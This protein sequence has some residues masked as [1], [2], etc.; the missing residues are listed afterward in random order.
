MNIEQIAAVIGI[1]ATLVGGIDLLIRWYFDGQRKVLKQRIKQLEQS[2]EELQAKVRPDDWISP[3]AARQ[4]G[5]L[6]VCL[7]EESAR[8]DA[9]ETNAKHVD[10]AATAKIRHMSLL[11]ESV[12]AEL[13]NTL[14]ELGVERDRNSKARVELATAAADL[15]TAKARLG[16]YERREKT[17][18]NLIKNTLELEGKIWTQDVLA[19]APEFLDIEERKTPIISVLNLKGGVGKTTVAA[20]LAWAMARKGYRLLLID[21][22]L[23]GSLSSLF[24]SQSALAARE[25]AGQLLRHFLAGVA[26]NPRLK[27]WDFAAKVERPG[28]TADLL[29]TT[30]S[31]AYQEMNLTFQWLLRVGHTGGQWT[32]KKDVRMLLRKA[33]HRSGLRKHYDMVLID[34]PPVMNL[35]CVNA[36]AASDG[37][38]IPVTPSRKAV[39][40]VPPLLDRIKE[41]HEQVNHRLNVIGL[42]ANRTQWKESLT[43][44][45]SD[46]WK[47]LPQKCLDVYGKPVHRFEAFLP[48]LT[49]IRNAEDD[50]PP[51]DDEDILVRV[52]KLA[53]ELEGRLPHF[54]RPDDTTRSSKK[55]AQA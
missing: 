37:V 40:R 42:I 17:Q 34:C 12:E 20:Y 51:R 32:G 22:D 2:V 53:V 16:T 5:E 14:T 46:L 25:D 55:G 11:K 45:E 39:E 36:L 4:I 10:E 47:A 3:E 19:A 24:M 38:V 31:L 6:K 41:I 29:G 43:P 48:Q 44:T 33:I 7:V 21:L 15:D 26:G 8:A 54:C 9:A 35:C 1:T 50:F 49:L 18:G 27:A 28:I 23:Q 30:D 52:D 13:H